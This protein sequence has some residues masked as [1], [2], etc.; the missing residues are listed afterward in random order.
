[1]RIL[2]L[3]FVY[4]LF[5][6]ANQI[7]SDGLKKEIFFDLDRSQFFMGNTIGL[8][9]QNTLEHENISPIIG[10]DGKNNICNFTNTDPCFYKDNDY[11]VSQ[12]ILQNTDL[13]NRCLFNST[14]DNYANFKT[15]I[16]VD[17]AKIVPLIK[18][19]KSVQAECTGV[20]FANDILSAQII[21]QKFNY[22]APYVSTS[23]KVMIETMV[24]YPLKL[25]NPVFVSRTNKVLLLSN[26]TYTYNCSGIVCSQLWDMTIIPTSYFCYLAYDVGIYF[27]ITCEN[28]IDC[29]KPNNRTS[30]YFSIYSN[31]TFCP[32]IAEDIE[33]YGYLNAKV[34]DNNINTIYN[35]SN[36]YFTVNLD[37]DLRDITNFAIRNIYIDNGNNNYNT[38]YWNQIIEPE[39]VQ[40]NL[41]FHNITTFS[42]DMDPQKYYPNNILNFVVGLDYT[43]N[44]TNGIKISYPTG[45]HQLVKYIYIKDTPTT[46]TRI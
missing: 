24:E 36:V 13:L 5:A 18:F 14:Y 34:N 15:N 27:D 39:G 12:I 28:N 25:S 38:F 37:S 43:Y 11:C 8:Y 26:N 33:P 17:N 31:G 22:V 40:S 30:I 29:I 32:T 2:L 45:E 7:N 20:D 19:P 1:M 10:V 4:I 21:K 3:L 35:K 46:T 41:V 9:F 23:M 16:Y 6:E 42:L 44:N